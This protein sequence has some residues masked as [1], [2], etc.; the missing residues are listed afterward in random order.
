MQ[1]EFH[2]FPFEE[3]ADKM[4]I[5]FGLK[6]HVLYEHDGGELLFEIVDYKN[7]SCLSLSY[8]IEDGIPILHADLI[9]QCIELKGEEIVP[10]L[11]QIGKMLGV[12]KIKLTDASQIQFKSL[13]PRSEGCDVNLFVLKILTTGQSWYNQFGF[14]SNPETEDIE[15]Y[16]HNELIRDKTL[17]EVFTI[18]QMLDHLG[19]ELKMDIRDLIE[20]ADDLTNERGELIFQYFKDIPLKEF[21]SYIENFFKTVRIDCEADNVQWFISF[22]EIMYNS[23]LIRYKNDLTYIVPYSGGKKRKRKLAKT[24]RNKKFAKRR[25]SRKR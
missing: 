9:R 1:S 18:M 8:K 16:K 11:I 25:N 22:L 3:V 5:I 12:Q 4:Q 21:A 13:N 14:F 20:D 15:I 7:S 2:D 19:S 10:K 17:N 23:Q 6:Y 24:S